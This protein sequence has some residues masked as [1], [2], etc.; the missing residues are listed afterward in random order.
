MAMRSGK[1]EASGLADKLKKQFAVRSREFNISANWVTDEK[2]ISAHA[3]LAGKP[4]GKALDL[5]CGTGQIGRALKQRGWDVR[6]LDICRDMLLASAHCFPGLEAAAEMMP[7]K[8]G[9]FH[10]V[11]CRQ[12]FQFLDTNKVLSEVARILA[13]QGVF[14]LSL[15]VPFSDMDKGWLYKIHHLKQPL[16]LK[17]YTAQDLMDELKGAGFLIEAIR[18]LTVRESI[19]RWMDYAP[20]LGLKIREGVISLVKHAPAAYKKIHRVEVVHGEVFEDWNWVIL[21]TTLRR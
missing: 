21:K 6:G 7:F 4:A 20:E 17:F 15:T 8:S 9:S 1:D 19:N 14:I 10:L 13:P 12:T 11:T 16:L 5:C 18:T 2:L 3:E